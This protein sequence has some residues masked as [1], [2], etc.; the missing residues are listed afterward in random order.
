V[1]EKN[2]GLVS[3]FLGGIGAPLD[4][5][6]DS[7]ATRFVWRAVPG[8]A[9]HKLV[10]GFQFGPNE[11]LTPIQG[12]S[13]LFLDYFGDRIERDLGEWDVALPYLSNI[14]DAPAPIAAL[15]RTI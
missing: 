14:S 1:N 12:S 10:K 15:G 7:D 6:S 9:V 3:D 5:A 8:S 2:I 11:H 13:S 4:E